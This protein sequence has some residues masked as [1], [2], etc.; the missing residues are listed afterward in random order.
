MLCE[1]CGKDVTATSRVRI[2]GTILWVFW[3]LGLARRAAW[4]HH[5]DAL[6][7]W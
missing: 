1:M 3:G 7:D 2:E 6:D 5:V 4:L